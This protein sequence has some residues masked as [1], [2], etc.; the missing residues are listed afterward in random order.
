MDVF[1]ADDVGNEAMVCAYES[2]SPLELGIEV[3]RESQP[4]AGK[5]G[6]LEDDAFRGRTGR[7]PVE[8]TMG[9]HVGTNVGTNERAL[10]R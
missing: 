3:A 2:R 10:K 5:S 4:A 7:E 6:V 8:L 1:V 9:T